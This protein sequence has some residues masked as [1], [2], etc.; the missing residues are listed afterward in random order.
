ME[1]IRLH[2]SVVQCNLE[3]ICIVLEDLLFQKRTSITTDKEMCLHVH[4]L[5]TIRNTYKRHGRK[6]YITNFTIS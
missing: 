2:L 6:Q 1:G 5:S 4:V 3:S